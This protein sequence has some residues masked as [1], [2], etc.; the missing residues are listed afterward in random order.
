MLLALYDALV[1]TLEQGVAAIQ[2]GDQSGVITLRS[3][4]QKQVLGI[5]EGLDLTAGDVPKNIHRLCLYVLE[6]LLS[7][8]AEAWEAS[9]NT[10]RPLKRAYEQIADQVRELENAGKLPPLQ[11]HSL[12]REILA[13]PRVW[14]RAE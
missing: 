5:V 6:L 13:P 1:R 3:T 7:D 12:T 10:V 11:S 9:L 8:T 2:A 14:L 4:A